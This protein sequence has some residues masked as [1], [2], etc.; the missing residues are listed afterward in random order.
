MTQKTAFVRLHKYYLVDRSFVIIPERKIILKA[1]NV[2]QWF[3]ENEAVSLIILFLSD[4][5]KIVKRKSL[6]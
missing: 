5:I 2:N 4:K 1:A 6:I 3:P